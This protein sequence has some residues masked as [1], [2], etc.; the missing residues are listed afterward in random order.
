MDTKSKPISYRGLNRD[1]VRFDDLYFV[2]AE[3][4]IKVC[5]IYGERQINENGTRQN[6]K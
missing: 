5:G 1:V 6:R 3:N 4:H 2:V